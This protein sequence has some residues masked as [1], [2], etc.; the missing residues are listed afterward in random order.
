VDAI[1]AILAGGRSTRLGRPKPGALLAGRPLIGY[2]IAAAESVEVEPWVVGKPD[3]PLPELKCRVILEPP[4][5]VHP[6][7][8]VIAAL[9]EAGDRAVVAVAADM[10]FVEDKLIAWL[11]SQTS[12]TVV[13]ALGR[14]QPLLA[15][16]GSADAPVLEEAVRRG[17]PAAQAALD[18]GPR[19][20]GEADLRRF[21]DPGR[22]LFNVNTESDLRRAEEIL[23]S[24]ASRP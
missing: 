11:A 3:T 24:L 15:R 10:P 17:V 9:R 14:V 18:L 4:E 22:L 7:A 21:G 16:Y 8:G 1:A 23:A 13:E 12:A 19:I 20:V 5:P 6:L 2:P